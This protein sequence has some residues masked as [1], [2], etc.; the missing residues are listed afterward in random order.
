MCFYAQE[1]DAKD[2]KIGL[3][4]S[5]GGAKG[6]AHIGA[7]K[8]IEEAGI[9]IDYI[10]G[11]SMGAIV[12]SLYASGYNGKQLDSIFSAV[13]FQT[14]IRDEVP[15]GAKT[16]YEK[17]ETD[18]YAITLPF[19]HYKLG[20]P[21]SLSKGQNVYNLLSHLTTHVRDTTDFSKLPIPFLCVATDLETGKPV[22]LE[23][24]YLPKAVTASGALPSL[25]SPVT[26]NEQVL[27][28]GGVTNNY[29]IDE[30]RAKGMDIII[31]V[32]VQDD[33]KKRK[34]INSAVQILVQINNFGMQRD[35]EDKREKTDLYIQPDIKDYTVVSFDEGRKIINSGYTAAT[36][37]KD[38]LAK[39][40][41]LQKKKERPQISF[42]KRKSYYIK[43]IE[44]E[45][46]EQYTRSYVIGKLKI[47][48]P[49]YITLKQ[50]NDGINNLAATGNYKNIDYR[51]TKN[52]DGT[53]K[54]LF[55]LTESKHKLQLRISAHYNDLYR[56]AFLANITRKRLFTNNDIAS[57]DFI[58]GD[59]LRYKANYYIDK[60]Y[61]WSIGLSSEYN[62]FDKN[63]T[64][65]FLSSENLI[66]APT[67]NEIEIEY[68]DFTNKIYFE[69]IFERNFLIGLGAEHKY[70]KYLSKNIGVDE[71]QNLQTIFE[72]T[73]YYNALGYLVYDS[74]ND[75]YFPKNGLI[76]QGD[77]KLYLFAQGRNEDF[78]SFSIAKARI[79]YA[80]RIID[81][82]SFFINSEGGFKIGGNDTSSFDFFLGGYGFKQ[83]NNILPFYGYEALSLR[84]DTYLKSSL[85]VDWEFARKNYFSVF[86]NIANIGEDL[87][88][89]KQWI[90]GVDYSGF[91]LGYGLETPLG[92]L[93]I[94]YTYSPELDKTEWHIAAG[95]KF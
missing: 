79:G 49:A 6:L 50:F 61:Y 40:A 87:F 46:V 58:V 55:K 12:G 64:S 20:F 94:K 41:L 81:N 57:L 48:T 16:F 65:K 23:S 27:I 17:K 3:V 73:N 59:N 62:F 18:R 56:T 38:E 83:V 88:S 90:D 33:L 75:T 37:Q 53:Y 31:G 9:Q 28:D 66:E 44:I 86:G 71:N 19:D 36:T 11:T 5:G 63:V 26:I 4:L 45:G 76:F 2:I 15:R 10:S 84:G 35:M 34:R 25:F 42:E 1:K 78:E 92:P 60:G 80:H 14:L 51:L 82:V 52:D 43:S 29:P 72:N 74:L 32:D 93:E 7:I 21:S 70:L 67:F 91:G 77:F 39:I 13:D 47:K 89:T 95:F 54:I 8:A 85:T 22:I 24:G 30:L 68:S 69:T